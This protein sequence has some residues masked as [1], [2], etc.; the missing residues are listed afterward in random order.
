LLA[1]AVVLF[2]RDERE[3]PPLLGEV[4]EHPARLVVAT[5]AALSICGSVLLALPASSAG[6]EQIGFLDA[7]FTAISATC[8]TGLVVVD[9]GSAFSVLGQGVV[10]VLI[11][12]GGLGIMT[13]YT[14]ALGA[15]GRRLSLRHELAVAGAASIEDQAHLFRALGRVLVVTF[16]FEAIGAAILFL[17][18][19]MGSDSI[20]MATWR[21]VFTSIS[22]FCNAGF[23]LQ[24][25][26]LISY[27][28]D[29]AVLN[30]V[31]LLIVAGG[32][33]PAV[34]LSLPAMRR[35]RV[36]PLQNRLILTVSAVLLV[37]AFVSYL[38]FEW[39][40][41][42]EG[43]SFLHKL[44]N[45]WF[46]SITL[47]TAGFNS[48]DLTRTQPVTQAMMNATMFVGG[49]PGGTSGG[50][51]TT[52]AA[53]LLLAVVAALRGRPDA[54]AFGR[55]VDHA[56]VYKAA[57][58]ATIGV[59]SVLVA[60]I[61]VLLTQSMPANVA[62]FEVVS[63][64]AT[65]GLSLGG[66]AE[67]DEIGKILIMICMFVGRIGPLTLFLFLMERRM[68]TPFLLPDEQVDVG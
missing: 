35:G 61:A 43:L 42:L 49:S 40:H 38:A 20:E 37:G 24:P 22:A 53:L 1:F 21:A 12:V 56:S 18:F 51:K 52:T 57:A 17:R 19:A 67:L 23:A 28:H 14:V 62:L 47:R 59:L 26:S 6:D 3:A 58:V 34:V 63:A 39:S 4:L 15:L 46:Q 13:F 55:R 36:V 16:V 8:V 11:Q 32:L 66:T 30:V 7:A 33:S 31:G 41:S 65:V 64:L 48:V 2:V 54:T 68:T 50:I 9:T 10:L 29:P 60:V 27:N 44:D 25:D 5:F 45:A